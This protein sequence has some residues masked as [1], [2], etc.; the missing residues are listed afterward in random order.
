MTTINRSA[1]VVRPRQLFLDW[2]HDAAPTSKEL[3]L[4]DLGRE[5]NVYLVRNATMRRRRGSTLSRYAH[6][7]EEELEGWYRPAS[8][9]P[10][11]RDFEA[12]DRWFEWSFHSVLVDLCDDALL[13]EET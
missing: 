7:F 1:I 9:W 3:T 13:R 2:L 4:S 8:S 12:F 10:E 11:R 5:P 6:I